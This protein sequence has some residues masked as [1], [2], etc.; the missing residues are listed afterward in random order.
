[1]Y[2]LTVAIPFI[3]DPA[4][5]KC[6]AG[7]LALDSVGRIIVSHNGNCSFEHPKVLLSRSDRYVCG[8]SVEDI[9]QKCESDYLLFVTGAQL[10]RIGEDALSR[11]LDVARDSRAGM[12][13]ADCYDEGSQGLCAHPLNDYQAGSIR[14]S[15]DFGSLILF[16][17][18]AVR[19][20][21]RS[22]GGIAAYNYCGLYDLR[23]K[24]STDHMPL[25]LQESL[26]TQ[27]T[28]DK[29]LSGEKNFDYVD[30]R[31]REMQVECE[32]A[33]TDHL[34]RTGAWLAPGEYSVA[35]TDA[36]FDVEAS[37]VIPVKNREKTIADA[38]R[39]VLAQKC[40]FEY[41]CIVVDNHSDDET[42]HIVRRMASA[43]SR[44]HLVVPENTGYRIGGCWNQALKSRH[45]GRYAIQLDSDDLYQGQDT[46]ARIV[47]C[48]RREHCAMV[49]GAYTLVDFDMNVIEPG[50][51]DHREWTEDNGR[52]NALRINGL[53]APRAFDTAL[54]RNM[55]LP[56]TSYGE[57][58]A[59]ALR[60]SRDYRIGRIYDSLYLCRRW[61]GNTDAALSLE[62]I[63][64]N[65]AYKDKIRTIEILARIG[66]NRK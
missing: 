54:V 32:R 49:I 11:M 4:F 45:C 8:V 15:F 48:F 13:Y 39:S 10:P 17:V 43:D 1:M 60:L 18:A 66:K 33:A 23:L 24:L 44:V 62:Q 56:D 37:V 36:H 35:D 22:Y 5:D 58:Y 25:H 40:A 41:N 14:E 27:R 47:D 57:D 63:N 28:V 65:D 51:I 26:Y 59:I 52:N 38:V 12:V 64:R 6:L 16:S 50:L 53:G 61:Q 7:F 31:N 9:F 2:P 30:P 46:I 55:L 21:L 34:K 19:T 29:R 42:A 20:A 3:E